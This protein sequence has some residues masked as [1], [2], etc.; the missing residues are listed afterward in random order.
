MQPIDAVSLAALGRMSSKNDNLSN[1]TYAYNRFARE[2]D[3]FVANTTWAFEAESCRA[4]Q[5]WLE[6]TNR[7]FFPV[8]PLFSST[9]ETTN[10]QEPRASKS[11]FIDFLDSMMEKYGPNSVVY[12]RSYTCLELTRICLRERILRDFVWKRLVAT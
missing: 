10:I 5:A 11:Y 8:G 4:V 1:L 9:F 2:S 7:P 3:G 12:V 6:E